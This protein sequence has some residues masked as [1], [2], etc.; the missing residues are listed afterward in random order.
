[1]KITDFLTKDRIL[2]NLE[3]KSK[4]NILREMAELFEDGTII[5]GKEDLFFFFL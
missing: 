3:S 2:F 1:M 5:E 4:N